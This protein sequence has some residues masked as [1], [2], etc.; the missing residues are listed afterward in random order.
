M[1][2]NPCFTRA[3]TTR[4]AFGAALAFALAVP[5]WATDPTPDL[6]WARAEGGRGYD[7]AFR[8]TAL[9]DGGTVTLGLF[10][11]LQGGTLMFDA[12]GAGQTTFP[13]ATYG[14]GAFLAKHNA[15][16]ALVWARSI[17]GGGTEGIAAFPDGSFVAL[18]D[19]NASTLLFWNDENADPQDGL[20]VSAGGATFAEIGTFVARYAPVGTIQS[21][22][23]LD[24][25]AFGTAVA[26]FPDGSFVV[27]GRIWP[28]SAREP[29]PSR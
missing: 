5:A 11:R 16:G 4:A 20:A 6:L 13:L 25:A 22:F 14:Y 19:V 7:N 26:A 28:G 8:V 15:S 17:E 9:P 27:S 2:R 24:E 10:D 18:G 1:F 29:R 21:A 23:L 3:T 12:G